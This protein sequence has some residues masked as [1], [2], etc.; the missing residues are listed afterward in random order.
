METKQKSL[1]VFFF[2][3]ILVAFFSRLY[4]P[5]ERS[6]KKKIRR[7]KQDE[8]TTKIVLKNNRHI[9]YNNK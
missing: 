6:E 2:S 8:Q 3:F 4:C 5:W 1:F 7:E 9:V